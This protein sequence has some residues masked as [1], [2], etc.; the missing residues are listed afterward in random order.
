MK[1]TVDVQDSA[2]D[3]PSRVVLA[4]LTAHPALRSAHFAMERLD[5]GT[6]SLVVTMPSPT[7]ERRRQVSIWLD[8]TRVPSLEFGAWHT[9]ADLWDSEPR[10]GLAQ[11][12]AYLERILRDEIVLAEDPAAKDELP[13]RVVDINDPDEVL[14][15]LTDPLTATTM[16]LLSWSGATDCAVGDLRREPA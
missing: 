7:G 11:M 16:K 2:L 13:S 10:I 1:E 9:H 4:T 8:E 14:D 15:E 5:D 3:E 6:W 12:L